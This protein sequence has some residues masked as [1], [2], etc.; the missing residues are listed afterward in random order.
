MEDKNLSRA[1]LE[2]TVQGVMTGGLT[3][4]KKRYSDDNDPEEEL[5][6]TV[7]LTL[8]AVGRGVMKD[9]SNTEFCLRQ[10]GYALG[11]S[12]AR[13]L[14]GKDAYT[15]DSRSQTKNA[16]DQVYGEEWDDQHVMAHTDSEGIEN[17]DYEEAMKRS[18]MTDFAYWSAL[19]CPAFYDSKSG[20]AAA[21]QDI[22]D[23]KLHECIHRFADLAREEKDAVDT[24][25]AMNELGF[26]PNDVYNIQYNESL[27]DQFDMP[28]EATEVLLLTPADYTQLWKV[29]VKDRYDDLPEEGR[30]E[31]ALLEEFLTRYFEEEDTVDLSNPNHALSCYGLSRKQ[32]I[33]AHD[34]LQRIEKA[35]DFDPAKAL[36]RYAQLT[37]E[38]DLE[39]VL[40]E[41]PPPSKEERE[42]L[43]G[44]LLD[45]SL[46]TQ[47]EHKLV[48]WL[49]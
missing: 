18:Y 19:S 24:Q 27:A 40:E 21:K 44:T 2:G 14:V 34:A 38:E 22:S 26:E 4:L 15:V 47:A 5:K 25:V 7:G 20:L 11:A 13:V 36:E 8:L 6:E 16:L 35:A 12:T 45:D 49:N 1:Y 17:L 33:K 31:Q 30:S 28:V 37:N 10:L 46:I 41:L 32:A 42:R 3:G 29:A 43:N 39:A 48:E 9:E 23:T